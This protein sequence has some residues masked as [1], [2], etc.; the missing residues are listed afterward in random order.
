MGASG[1]F[2]GAQV[3]AFMSTI[4][5]V[6]SDPLHAFL[7][8]SILEKKYP[9]V[10]RVSDAAEAFCLV[11]QPLFAGRLGLV[12]SGSSRGSID[13]PAFVAELHERLP[14]VPVVVLGNSTEAG[15]DYP[16]E[17]VRYLSRPHASEKILEAAE[18]LLTR[19]N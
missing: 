10:Q 5:L 16:R 13:S 15:S 4:L 12:V 14:H 1:E 17:Y 9:D 11:E 8:K 18:E 7:F 2:T 3:S 19:H 6:D